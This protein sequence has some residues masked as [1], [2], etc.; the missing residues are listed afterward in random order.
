VW[1]LLLRLLDQRPLAVV[2]IAGVALV[3]IDLGQIQRPEVLRVHVALIG[4][5]QLGHNAGLQD[6][7]AAKSFKR[8]VKEKKKRRFFCSSTLYQTRATPIFDT[9][10]CGI[11][12]AA[13]YRK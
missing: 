11:F 9:V 4:R 7:S 13:T 5:L 1:S 3:F 8:M 6:L 12:V 10:N 2:R